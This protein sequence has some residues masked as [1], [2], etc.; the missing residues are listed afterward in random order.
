[1]Y[2]T[3][4]RPEPWMANALCA[5]VDGDL[6]FPDKG[7]STREAKAICR[8]CPVRAQCLALALEQGETGIWGGTSEN[9][10][11]RMKPSAEAA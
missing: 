8:R 5:Q 11:R 9:E 1:M 7:G 2:G 3:L 6:W 4:A 10:R